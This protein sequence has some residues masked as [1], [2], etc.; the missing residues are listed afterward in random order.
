M[1]LVISS[2]KVNKTALHP[3]GVEYVISLRPRYSFRF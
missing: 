3:G 2:N 1:V